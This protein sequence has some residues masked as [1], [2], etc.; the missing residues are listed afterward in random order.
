MKVPHASFLFGF[1]LLHALWTGSP[2]HGQ[3]PPLSGE[4][5]EMRIPQEPGWKAPSYRGWELLSIPGLIATYYDLDLDGRLDYQVI[6]K[7]I[8]KGISAK[9]TIPDAIQ[10]AR[11]DNLTVYISNP[12]I[13]FTSKYPLFYCLGVDFRRNCTNIWVDVAEDGLNGNETLYSLSKPQ[14]QDR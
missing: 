7:I 14:I 5:D 1:V 3:D 8:R 13:Y 12:V 9:M 2:A 10:S 11:I 6:R 4:S